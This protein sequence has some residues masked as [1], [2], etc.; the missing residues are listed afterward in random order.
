M[1]GWSEI[2]LPLSRANEAL[3]LGS[4]RTSWSM[5]GIATKK[6]ALGEIH[7]NLAVDHTNTALPAVERATL[8]RLSVAPVWIINAQWK[9]GVDLGVET[10]PEP[11]EKR[12]LA[13]TQLGLIHSPHRSIDL[14]LGI[15][16]HIGGPARNASAAFGVT[17]H[18]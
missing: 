8:Y 11:N 14:S 15:Q 9:T 13:Y 12:R 2:R 4:A 1:A 17:W 16:R 3:G 6:I 5:N 18:F 7:F 10:N